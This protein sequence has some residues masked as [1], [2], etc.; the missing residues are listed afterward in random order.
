MEEIVRA[1]NFVIDQGW[2]SALICKINAMQSNFNTNM[3]HRHFTGRRLSGA[4]VI[5]KRP[6]V[7]FF[8]HSDKPGGATEILNIVDVANRLNLIAPIAEQCLHK[9]VTFF[10][11]DL[12][13]RLQMH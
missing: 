7:C 5:S 2:V 6:T 10:M 11:A 4:P 12:A 13:Q 1:F 3:L 8:Y 9:R